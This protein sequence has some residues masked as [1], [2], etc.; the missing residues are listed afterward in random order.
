MPTTS[1]I[2]D[3]DMMDLLAMV[4]GATPAPL[5]TSDDSPVASLQ[6]ASPTLPEPEDDGDSPLDFMEAAGVHQEKTVCIRRRPWMDSHKFVL[7][8]TIEELRAV[9][10]EAINVT[11]KCALD[12]ETQGLDTRI[13]W[14]SVHDIKEHLDEF[15][16]DLQAT[17]IVPE[18]VHKIV[19]YCLSTDGQTGYYIPI[20][21]TADEA[22]NIDVGLAA[23]EISRLCHASQ[24]VLTPKGTEE[25]PLA[26]RDIA[27]PGKVKL[28]FWHAKFDQEFLFPVSGIDYWHPDSFEDGN[29]LYF[30][31]KTSDKQL[32]LKLKAAQELAIRKVVIVTDNVTKKTTKMVQTHPYEMIELKELFV[33]STGKKRDIDFASL[34][35]EEAFEYG[36]SDG[37]CTF[38]LCEK[39]ENVEILLGSPNEKD[40]LELRKKQAVLS[41]YRLEKQV[42]QVLRVMERNRIQIDIEF[43][44]ALFTEATLE[45]AEYEKDIKKVATA[46]NF[47]DLDLRSSKQLSDFLFTDKGLD[48]NPKPLKNEASGQYKT[49]AD[50]IE[51]LVENN[52]QINDCVIKI[53]KF[54]QIDK[55][56]STYLTNMVNYCD[57]SHE[58]RYQFKQTGAATARF[59]APAGDVQ[60]GYSGVPIHG[61]PATY[62]DKKP[63]VATSL[64]K[65]FIAR[66][67]YTML[68][69][70]FAGEELRIATNL[71]REPVWTDEFMN[72]SGDLHS[73]TARAF[74]NKSEVSPQERQMG[75]TSNFA[76]LYGGGAM[77][78][79][80]ATGCTQVEAQRRKAN[81]DKALPTFAKWVRDQKARCHKEKGV[82]TAFGRWIAIPEIDSPEKQVSAGAERWS[83]NYPI[84]G[85]G[86]DIMKIV[87]V[88]LHKEFF[89]RKW[90]QTQQVR[91][92]LTVHD[93]IVFEVKHELL[94]EAMEV[95]I[96]L[97]EEPGRM[98]RG[99][100]IP[101]V[102]E[103]LIGK[104]W[105][106][107][108]DWNAI[109]KGKALKPDQKLKDSQMLVEGRVYTKV[110][111]WLE[112]LIVPAW[113]LAGKV[114]DPT[115][116]GGEGGSPAGGSSAEVVPPTV[117][118]TPIMVEG[119]PSVVVL[120]PSAP[121]PA[122]FTPVPLTGFKVNGSNGHA[123]GHV[124][125]VIDEEDIVI[126]TM[127][128]DMMN[129]NT[130]S[131]VHA[132]CHSCADAHGKILHLVGKPSG[133]TLIDPSLSIRVDPAKFQYK[134]D[135]HN[136]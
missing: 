43:V 101:L 59:S 48:I 102:A 54:R 91:M 45:A 23:A 61:I 29:L 51:E 115:P 39:P 88:L 31:R 16:P 123:N 53:V 133:E 124:K 117:Y 52:P 80:R 58:I 76:L 7:V 90:L 85:C 103:A 96:R 32:S 118:P 72:G 126:L 46:H 67:S 114:A 110:P 111:D 4:P 41:I 81:F 66:P 55:V 9:V 15:S 38:L 57:A 87:M 71:S 129:H 5:P 116:E 30:C 56:V 8:K 37:I 25:D 125:H 50:T 33:S 97:M 107:K 92:L 22:K 14:K 28:F 68:K 19:G 74:F 18:T 60:Q 70:D 136:L 83:I 49:D 130:V 95:I 65:A 73:I 98:A 44:R 131:Q 47:F 105:D 134:L 21:H 13:Y 82:F 42:A 113:Q 6:A 84:Q 69:V 35:P 128:D 99:W 77:S 36:S 135:D 12:L 79:V 24:P 3:D 75:K 40:P 104:T 20:R 89:K 127:A 112:G 122:P 10:D 64:R 106:A 109:V 94:Q 119:G 11:H 121:I 132:A 100:T 26:S 17:G 1:V 34:H 63:K 2:D 86:A 62:D 78:I 27:E 120:A 93:E 108:Y